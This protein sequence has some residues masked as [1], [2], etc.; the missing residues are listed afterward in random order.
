MKVYRIEAVVYEEGS[1]KQEAPIT[2]RAENQLMARREALQ[3]C[4]ESGLL[5]HRFISITKIKG[6]VI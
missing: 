4:W 1:Y 2:V 5:I 6:E 3:I